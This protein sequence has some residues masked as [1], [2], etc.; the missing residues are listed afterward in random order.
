M[1]LQELCQ[2]INLPSEVTE[3]VLLYEKGN[4]PARLLHKITIP[5]C[6]EEA[7][8]ELAVWC[9]PQN[10]G[11]DILAY[12]LLAAL[13]TFQKYRD[14]GIDDNIYFHTMTC[15]TRFVGEHKASFGYYG[16]DRAWWTYRQLSMVL[17]RIGE[18]EYEFADNGQPTH[19]HIPSNANIELSACRKSLAGFRAFAE[20][21][22]PAKADL[23]IIMSSWLLSPALDKVLP[24]DSKIIQFKNCFELVSWDKDNTQFM[25][26]IYGREDIPC[27]EL[28]VKTSLQRTVKEHLAQGGKIGSARGVLKSFKS[29]P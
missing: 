22:Y 16:F 11:F 8:K 14:K 17:F 3:Q 21:H 28:P 20:K 12:E 4:I 23:P 9:K 18:L 10:H 26:W 6:A 19:L 13:N 7:Y 27:H 24:A 29:F 1:N 2:R 5:E 25:Q 15:F